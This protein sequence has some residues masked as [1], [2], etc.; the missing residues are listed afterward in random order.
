MTS[1][2]AI[3][4]RAL[5]P[6]EQQQR[7]ASFI[8]G[9]TRPALAVQADTGTG[10]SAVI[11]AAA[12]RAAKQGHR[13][14][15]S[16]HTIQ[17]LKQMEREAH[18]FEREGANI[19][20]RLGMRNFVSTSRVDYALSRKMAVGTLSSEDEAGFSALAEFARNGSGL[21]E[22]F[23]SE[24]GD[25]P[26]GLTPEDI[27]LLPSARA[28]DKAAWREAKGKADDYQITIQTHALTLA[29]ARY[30]QL[31]DIAIFDEADAL[32]DVAESADDRRLSL[33]GLSAVMKLVG[34]DQSPLNALLAAPADVKRR[35]ALAEALKVN[36]DEEEI[37]FAL[38]QA[39]W[40]L[41]SHR[42]DG[43]RR[44]TEVKREGSDTIIRS[45][46][47]DR[48]RWIWRNL[49]DAGV[50]RAIFVSAT[51][52]I[53]SPVELALRRY[54]VPT[55]AVDS[56]SV[57]P[58]KFGKVAF[59]IVPEATP[60]PIVDGAVNPEWQQTA[61]QWLM[62]NGL[63]REGSRPFVLAKSYDDAAVFAN[64]LGL[65]AHQRGT[66]LTRHVE[67]FRQGTI[68]GLVTPAGWSGVD[69]P[70]LI[71]DLVILRLPYDGVDEL[72][73]QLLGRT[74]FPAL[75]ASMQRKFRQGL[76]RGIRRE[77]DEVSV[78]LADPRVHDLRN[79]IVAA[80][81]ERF[82]DQFL[83]ALGQLRM[84]ASPIRTEQAAFRAALLARYGRCAISGFT[85]EGALEAAHLP[86]R[87][88][89]AGHNKAEDGI[90]LRA[91]IHALFDSGAI[92]IENGIVRVD[93]SILA[94]YGQYDGKPIRLG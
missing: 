20:T 37:R 16:T 86:G 7:L 60:S 47:A 26:S 90:L 41:T 38:S 8:D 62:D 27:C 84:A 75:K 44:G 5:R 3:L 42:L 55:D 6:R 28:A 89:K 93:E 65:T 13:V 30:G 70:G 94:E 19:G 76:G 9:T 68:R 91:D 11:L 73:S 18:L 32:G 17:L 67:Q 49:T 78:W 35:E 53:G 66:P 71:T 74:D 14:V 2:T 82:R 63:M 36:H 45:L 79:G 12:I 4:E 88:W 51:L 40:I 69:L 1:C 57:S 24:Y 22:E 72:R 77:E 56:C 61:T 54:G 59:H 87:S 52:A 10:K 80:I 81:P 39:R 29:Q 43:P 83:V 58:R 15:I 85:T 46:W 25:L 31:P 50:K 23:L 21:I 33:S 64:Q 34:I 48:S 92:R